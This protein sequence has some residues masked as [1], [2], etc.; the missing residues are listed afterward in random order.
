LSLNKRRYYLSKQIND[1]ASQFQTI[2]LNFS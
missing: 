1:R 2:I